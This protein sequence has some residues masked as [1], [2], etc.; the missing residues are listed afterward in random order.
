M[1]ARR[2]PCS[3]FKV[4]LE[5]NSACFSART[6]PAKR[7]VISLGPRVQPVQEKASSSP[8]GMCVGGNQLHFWV[9]HR[10]AEG[11][12]IWLLGSTLHEFVCWEGESR[13]LGGLSRALNTDHCSA[14]WAGTPTVSLCDVSSAYQSRVSFSQPVEGVSVKQLLWGFHSI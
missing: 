10:R 14:K 12:P 11:I 6:E 2:S 5:E 9:L 13:C 1:V 8:A 7:T 4:N 3:S